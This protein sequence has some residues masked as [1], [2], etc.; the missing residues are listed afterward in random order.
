[1]ITEIEDAMVALL[2]TALTGVLVDSFPD[3]AAKYDKLPFNKNNMALVA[4]RG[5]RFGEPRITDVVVQEQTAEFEVNLAVRNLKGQQGAYVLL[6]SIRATLTGSRLNGAGP[7]YPTGEHFIKV[8][9]FIWEYFATFACS[10]PAV[11]V[12]TEPTAP[13]FAHGIFQDAQTGE[14]TE[15]IFA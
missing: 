14:I 8:E 11:Q 3:T 13:P 15:V 2:K 9:E 4:Y 12:I 10:W 5:S 6:E 1:V 7:L